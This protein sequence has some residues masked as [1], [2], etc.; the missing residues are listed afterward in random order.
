MSYGK[1]T[2]APTQITDQIFIGSNKHGR[3]LAVSN[4]SGIRAVLNVGT[5]GDYAR[6]NSIDYM[7]VPLLD[8][9][10]VS[11]DEQVAC[12]AF[13]HYHTDRGSRV[14]IHCNAGRNRSAAIA[15]AHF[16]ISGHARDYDTA[17]RFIKSKREMCQIRLEIRM[18]ILFMIDEPASISM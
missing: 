3:D 12:L 9:G 1:A 11:R 14:L 13:I 17:L 4:P 6:A 5:R 7:S 2:A 18:S 16:L 10:P 15:I 8:S